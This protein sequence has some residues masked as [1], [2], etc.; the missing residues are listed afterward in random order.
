MTI[1]FKIDR[2]KTKQELLQNAV[3]LGVAL[4]SMIHIHNLKSLSSI[5][6]FWDSLLIPFILIGEIAKLSLANYYGMK[7]KEAIKKKHSCNKKKQSFSAA[8]KILAIF[9]QCAV[10][11]L[12]GFSCI[13]L[14]APVLQ[15][16]EQTC[17][18]SMILTLLTVSPLVFMLGAGGTLQVWFCEK[19]ENI[20]KA[21]EVYISLYKYHAIGAVVGAWVGSVVV[22]LDWDKDW[23]EY[24]IPNV[25]GAFCGSGIATII[26]TASVLHRIWSSILCQRKSS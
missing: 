1:H 23:Q 19:V 9:I 16:Y 4:A 6:R 15:D 17:V 3:N 5:G 25:I 20:V 21:E 8:D 12:Y 22:P 10:V 2:Q 7:D 18:L 14:G 11:V 24:P 26:S 13:L